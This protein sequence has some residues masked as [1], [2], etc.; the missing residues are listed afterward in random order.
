MVKIA[1][2]KAREVF[3][4][5]GNPTIEVDV[6]LSDGTMGR[7][8]VPS[9][10]STGTS[11]ALEMRDKGERLKGKGVLKAVSN[12]NTK[13]KESLLGLNPLS[14][15][16]I[17]SLLIK[18]DGSEN[19]ENL[20]AN[21]ILGVSMAVAR[22]SA[23]FLKIPLYRYIGGLNAHIL[24]YPLLNIINGGAHANNRLDVQ[25][26]MIIPHKADTFRNAFEKAVNIYHTLKEI[27]SKRG[28]S[29]S[30]G[31]E[32]GFAPDLSS[33]KE[34]LN[35][36]VEAIEKGGYKAGE[37]VSIGLD[38]AAS[39]IYRDGIYHIDNQRL[40]SDELI[41]YYQSLIG[42][43]PIISIE[44]GL[45]EE[46]WDAWEKMTEKLKNI[47]IVGDDIFTTNPK[48]LKKGIERNIANAILIKLNQI[49]SLTETLDTIE[50]AKRGGYKIIISHRSGETEDSFIADLCVATQGGQIKSGAPARTER[51]CKYNQLL[52]IEEELG[53]SSIYGGCF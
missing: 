13:I 35:L 5:R 44:D 45:S 29:T 11:E 1:D 38:V 34:A 48:R 42:Q 16:E 18:L 20:G 53:N 17:D 30:V 25:E 27:I 15:R 40:G 12:V 41:E 23:G 19:K 7:A 51:C 22:A 4:S 52:R 50:L 31:D 3:D 26:F 39:E 2:V 36:I 10:A 49:G 32:G 14:Q 43:F 9:G 24:P 37:E 28:Y 6:V 8:G 33:T 47:Q 21:A 46:D